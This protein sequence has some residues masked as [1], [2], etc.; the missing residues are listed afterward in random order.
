MLYGPPGVGKTHLACTA[1]DI[2]ELH[3]ILFVNVEGGLATVRQFKK[4]RDVITVKKWSECNTLLRELK[5]DNVYKTVI[6]DTVTQAAD[7]NIKHIML[8]KTRNNPNASKQPKYGDF[9][10]SKDQMVTWVKDLHNLNKNVILITHARENYS[11]K[12]IL[13]NIRL[14]FNPQMGNE[15]SRLVDTI[16]YLILDVSGSGTEKRTLQLVPTK[17]ILAKR[18]GDS[19]MKDAKGK[20]KPVP[21][22]V[23]APTMKKLLDALGFDYSGISRRD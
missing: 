2:P 12:N 10:V 22:K 15:I 7:M 8:V 11:D 1:Q 18:R 17:M 4:I 9:W 13:I 3:P 14:A 21:S 5:R 6:I 23:E 16:G 19:T 20:I